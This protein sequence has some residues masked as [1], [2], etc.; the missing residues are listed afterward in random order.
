M[1]A[2]CSKVGWLEMTEENAMLIPMT[3]RLAATVL[4]AITLTACAGTPVTGQRPPSLDRLVSYAA[5]PVDHF[6][7]EQG[8]QDWSAVDES[9][10]LIQMRDGRAYLVSVSKQCTN[11]HDARRIKLTSTL[12][13]VYSRKL[14]FVRARGKECPIER[15]LPIDAQRLRAD[16]GV[17]MATARSEGG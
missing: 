8:L 12:G 14:D 15:I 6:T 11:L 9:T 4:A 17:E 2:P 16:M 5:Q 10:A 13:T 7:L 1:N 3:V